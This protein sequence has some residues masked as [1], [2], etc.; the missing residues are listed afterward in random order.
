[1]QEQK[2]I[3]NRQLLEIK[4]PG[5][6]RAQLIQNRISE[7]VKYKLHPAMDT[8][9]SKMSASNE[10]IKIDRLVIDIGNIAEG[11]I[12]NKLVKSA[13]LKL[14]EDLGKLI[15]SAASESDGQN[16]PQ[17]NQSGSDVVRTVSKDEETLSQFVFFL[18]Y[19]YLPW[20]SSVSGE[21]R[22][23]ILFKE[24]LK[25]KTSA[26]KNEIL[27]LLKYRVVTERLVFQ[28]S[29]GLLKSLLIKT[30]K[31]RFTHY[32]QQFQLVK[33]LVGSAT[34]KRVLESSFYPVLF[35][36]YSS[37]GQSFTEKQRLGFVR[38]ILHS[39]YNKLSD[40]AKRK[41]VAEW[42]KEERKRISEK[43]IVLNKLSR[44]SEF[45]DKKTK[46]GSPKMQ[47]KNLKEVQRLI[48]L[49]YQRLEGKINTSK[50]TS[51]NIGSENL[52][53]DEKSVS[54]PNL[55]TEELSLF[56]LQNEKG[57]DGIEV[58]NAGL[59]L[60]H[61]FLQY[62]FKGLNLLNKELKFKN[63]SSI[64]KAIH[65]LQFIVTGEENTPETELIFN[66]ILCGLEVTAPVPKIEK[67][68]K[69]EKSECEFLIQTVLERWDALK[70]KNPVAL[71]E[72][73]LQRNGILKKSGES[74]SINIERN[75][76]D[77]MLEKL[78]WSISLFKLPW[79]SQIIYVEW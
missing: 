4:V 6:D 12:E 34:L 41:I 58:S 14:Q 27:P 51:S 35:G 17:K 47:D 45:D 66:K 70:T 60:V 21:N 10:I 50:K 55:D 40:A 5:N 24:I 3:I 68:S 30:D 43:D 7:T 23:E 78:P 77:V 29:S 79:L 26:L 13:L 8:L 72:T 28:F 25:N 1:L 19:G 76:F 42:K 73:F 15:K 36:Y 75:A 49:F 44:L 67:L 46:Q 54:N 20:W 31:K 9:F 16:R 38:D 37:A 18:K 2:H 63:Q 48:L 56:L 71:R 61:P 74:W 52:K 32:F 62:F 22:L 11:D 65:L 64:Y 69:T 57:S 39:V 53:L 33:S 59:V